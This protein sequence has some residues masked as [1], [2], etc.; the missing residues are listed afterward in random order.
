[1]GEPYHWKQGVPG[2]ES[3]G[4]NRRPV[5][6]PWQPHADLPLSSE[7]SDGSKCTGPPTTISTAHKCT[8]S[9]PPGPHHAPAVGISHPK[10]RTRKLTRTDPYSLA[11]NWHRDE[12]AVGMINIPACPPPLTSNYTLGQVCSQGN[13]GGTS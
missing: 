5:R 3:C 12:S 1:M 6:F 11:H 13:G 9:H 7:R 2:Q 4:G 10:P 8:L